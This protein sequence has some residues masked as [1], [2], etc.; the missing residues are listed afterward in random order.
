MLLSQLSGIVNTTTIAHY[1]H[2]LEA[3]CARAVKIG[4]Y[5]YKSIK[6]ILQNGL[7]LEKLP[8]SSP[9]VSVA[10]QNIRGG[11]YFKN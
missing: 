6:S 1:Q 10:H 5:T 7:D 8:E 3:A 2:L 4:A 11:D 9:V